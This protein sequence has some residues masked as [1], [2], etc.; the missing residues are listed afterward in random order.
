MGT[1]AGEMANR[2]CRYVLRL[3]IAAWGVMFAANV[4]AAFEF[5]AANEATTFASFTIDCNR[6]GPDSR[7]A[8]GGNT[9]AYKNTTPFLQELVSIDGSTYYHSVVGDPASDF[10]Q[11]VYIRIAGCCYP[12][13]NPL[14]ASN[15]N[16]DGN[17]T[18]VA[19][20]TLVQDAELTQW[21]TKDLL[22]FKPLITQ[23][24]ETSELLLNFQAD[25]S[26]INYSTLATPGDVSINLQLLQ[27]AFTDAGNYDS[28]VTPDFLVIR[29][30]SCRTSR[31]DV[32]HIRLVAVMAVVPVHIPT[33]VALGVTSNT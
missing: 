2:V 32:I 21:F 4:Q 31:L 12:N 24:I 5:G 13:N 9:G 6:G 18:R 15:L 16:G 8:L 26:A 20:R 14:S 22:A 17:P 25:M 30:M 11:E 7:C 3:L 23:S 10:L 19:M 29:Q 28:T 33:G 1:E 27:D